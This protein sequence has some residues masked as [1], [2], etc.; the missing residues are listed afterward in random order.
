MPKPT[1]AEREAE[2]AIE[3]QRKKIVDEYG[4]LDAE[5]VPV[6]AKLRRS[7][8]LAKIIRSWH[9]ET[10]EESV[11]SAGDRYK[12]VLSICGLQTRIV[13]MAG[14]YQALGHDRFL[15]HASVTLKA[16]EQSGVDTAAIAALTT[17][18]RTGSRSLIAVPVSA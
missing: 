17:K 2:K 15:E 7:D 3:L 10:P 12:V 16:L 1:K 9:A 5:L 13:S 11:T 18:E 8:E 14:V 6:R 4:A